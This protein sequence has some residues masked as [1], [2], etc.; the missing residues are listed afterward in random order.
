MEVCEDLHLKWNDFRLSVS[1]AFRELRQDGDFFDITLAASDSGNRTLRAH[2]V[3]LAACSA[4]FKQMLREQPEIKA[5]PH[6]Y[7]YMKGVAHNNLESILDFIYHGEVFISQ[8][9]LKPFLAL[10]EELKIKGLE[11]KEQ[12]GG[13]DDTAARAGKMVKICNENGQQLLECKKRETPKKKGK[14]EATKKCNT[15]TIVNEVT[16]DEDISI[17][18]FSGSDDS[19]IQDG[20]S[21]DLMAGESRYRVV[22]SNLPMRRKGMRWTCSLCSKDFRDRNLCVNHIECNHMNVDYNCRFQMCCYVARSSYKLRRHELA[23]HNA[24]RLVKPKSL[25]TREPALF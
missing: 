10:A 3:L 11:N 19:G 15:S 20:G 13:K 16:V 2:K 14:M 6:P 24:K 9:D 23:A 12:S 17:V 8:K 22:N 21:G 4:S 7:I 5:N 1:G 25:L 18:G